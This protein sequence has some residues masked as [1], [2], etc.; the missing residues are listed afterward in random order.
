M[1]V[2]NF[3]IKPCSYCQ[4]F[5]F[6]TPCNCWR[7]GSLWT[8]YEY[9]KLTLSSSNLTISLHTLYTSTALPMVRWI[10]FR[11]CICSTKSRK[12]SSTKI[13]YN[14]SA[15]L[16]ASNLLRSSVIPCSTLL[17]SDLWAKQWLIVIK[18][19]C[20]SW[21]GTATIND[22]CKVNSSSSISQDR[23]DAC[24]SNLDGMIWGNTRG[25]GEVKCFSQVGNT[26]AIAKDLVRL[27]LFSKNAIDTHGMHG[28]LAFQAIGRHVFFYLT[29]LL[30]DAL[31]VMMEIGKIEIPSCIM[32]LPAYVAQ[33]HRLL[34]VLALYDEMCIP[35]TAQ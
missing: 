16:L 2:T 20:M 23:P 18:E 5:Q 33:S 25:F 17:A 13:Q 7:S 9:I 29:T 10:Y 8:V 12:L 34:D 24:I 6:K 30:N 1:F 28:I 31:Y 14:V 27:A 26:F 35:W 19:L 15:A 3:G 22:E 21:I 4:G 32:D 11:C